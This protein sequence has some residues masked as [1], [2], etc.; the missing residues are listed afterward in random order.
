TMKSRLPRTRWLLAVAVTACGGILLARA[1]A[2]SQANPE[3]A[4]GQPASTGASEQAAGQALPPATRLRIWVGEHGGNSKE[5]LDPGGAAW[6]KVLPTKA[7][8]NR[9]PRVYKAEPV[10]GLPLPPPDA[11][12]L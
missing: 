8:L 7:I 1:W 6:E 12:R 2:T 9:T 10:R 4:S 3:S 11:R 5:L